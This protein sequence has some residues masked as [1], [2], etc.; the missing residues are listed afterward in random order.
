MNEYSDSEREAEYAALESQRRQLRACLR[1][2]AETPPPL[3]RKHPIPLPLTTPPL[4]SLIAPPSDAGAQNNSEAVADSG[5]STVS[6]SQAQVN[7]SAVPTELTRQRLPLSFRPSRRCPSLHIVIPGSDHHEPWLSRPI[8]SSPLVCLFRCASDVAF[9]TNTSLSQ[10]LV[11]MY[12]FHHLF[13]SM[14]LQSGHIL[15]SFTDRIHSHPSLNPQ[16]CP[17][18]PHLNHYLFPNW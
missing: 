5:L 6:T 16:Y 3:E 4:L 8:C 12:L 13:F 10:G 2:E 15:I 17:I 14:H 11:Q 7:K 18:R 9:A 1:T